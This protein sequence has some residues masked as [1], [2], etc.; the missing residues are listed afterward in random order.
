MCKVSQLICELSSDD[1]DDDC[2]ESGGDFMIGK[3]TAPWHKDFNGYLHSKDQ[4]GDMT[5]IEWWGVSA[6][7][8]FLYI[9]H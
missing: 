8:T 3:S 9:Y 1:D 5:I 7:C 6:F 4:L 2:I